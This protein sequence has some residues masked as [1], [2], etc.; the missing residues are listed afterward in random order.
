MDASF[1]YARETIVSIE[2]W[3]ELYPVSPVRS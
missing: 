3:M 1:S 2:A